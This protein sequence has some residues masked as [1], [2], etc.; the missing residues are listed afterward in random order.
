MELTLGTFNL[1]NLFDR[2]NFEAEIGALPARSRSVRTT[3][4]WV[5]MG[6]GAGPDDPPPQLDPTESTS[7]IYRIKRNADG[8]LIKPKSDQGL[9]AVASRIDAMAADV[10]CVQEVENLDSLRAFNRTHLAD[11]YRYEVLVEGNDPRF[12]DV[13][14]LSRLPVA[15]VTSHRFE[16]HPSDP[17]MPIFGRDLLEVDIFDPARRKKLLTVYVNH[18]KSKFIRFDDP[19][20]AATDAANQLRRRRQAETVR[21]VVDARTRPNSRYVIVGDMNDTP[22]ADSL[23]PIADG[24]V[25]GLANPVES[26]QPPPVSNPGDAP[27]GTRWTH[28]F[29][30]S[31]APD[32]YDLLDQIWLSPALGPKLAHAQIERRI[33]W[34]A[35]ARGVGSDHDPAWV[36]LSGL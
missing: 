11:P 19:D 20:P 10:L 33:K 8:A 4:Q 27:P 21:R 2:F 12:I 7:P 26:R 22:E 34:T 3:Y 32:H 24:M 16:V 23:A 25:D 36:R 35:T 6:E 30:V 13:A 9:Q 28:R 18:L 14:I 1:N 17:A 15:N 5:V 29:R 31:G